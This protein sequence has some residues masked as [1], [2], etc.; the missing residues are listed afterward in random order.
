MSE[1][2]KAI[3]APTNPNIPD[4][5]PGD[6]VSVHVK[7]KEGNRERIQEFKGTVLF[8]KRNGTNST[9]TVRRVASNG[10]GVERTFLTRSPRVEKVVVERHSKVRRARLYFLRERTGKSARL[11]QRFS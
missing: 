1:L 2:L 10:V 4:L 3:E 6:V 9:F 7:I 11:K 8:L 5:R